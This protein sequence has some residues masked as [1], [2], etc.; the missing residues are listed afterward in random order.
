MAPG[1]RHHGRGHFGDVS[2]RRGG[3]GGKRRRENK[4]DRRYEWEERQSR[5]R[6]HTKR[7]DYIAGEAVR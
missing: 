3:S 4:S 6:R 2:G 7:K 1:N 5:E